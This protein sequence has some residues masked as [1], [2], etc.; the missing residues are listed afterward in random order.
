VRRGLITVIVAPVGLLTFLAAVMLGYY[1]YVTFNSVL[2]PDRFH[3]LTV[4]QP[5][6]EVEAV[7]P[8]RETIDSPAAGE[9]P[10]PTGSTCRYYR[11]DANLLGLS[12]VYRLC[13][14]DDRLVAKDVIPTG[15]GRPAPSP[16]G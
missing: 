8:D 14:A 6:A 9:P 12:R 10:A 13:F 16:T 11:P 7:L 3:R 2:A 15:V 4:G 5:S 1:V